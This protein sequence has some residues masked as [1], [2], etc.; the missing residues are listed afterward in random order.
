MEK[1]ILSHNIRLL[2]RRKGLTQEAFAA[3]IGTTAVRLARLECG[4]EPTVA[5]VAALCR[6]LDAHEEFLLREKL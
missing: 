3:L 6:V 2:R 1:T 4:A 5:E